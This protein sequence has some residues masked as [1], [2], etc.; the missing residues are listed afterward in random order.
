[1][2]IIPFIG[3]LLISLIFV[4]SA[5]KKITDFDSVVEKMAEKG[6]GATE[7]MLAGAIAFLVAGSLSLILGY[8]TRLG[9]FL[10]ILFL[11]PVTIIFHFDL[12]DPSQKIALLKNIGLI[13]GLLMVISNGAG[14]WS[15]DGKKQLK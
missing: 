13:G 2:R 4:S 3:R 1:M 14:A 6:I 10:L 9:A 7:F 11:V 12:S 5:F 8:K 15:I